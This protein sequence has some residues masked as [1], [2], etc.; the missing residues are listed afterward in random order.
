MPRAGFASSVAGIAI[1]GANGAAPRHSH[2]PTAPRGVAPRH[3]RADGVVQW[4]CEENQRFRSAAG[5]RRLGER[6]VIVDTWGS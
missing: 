4:V 6:A 2:R 5:L 3:S 1:G